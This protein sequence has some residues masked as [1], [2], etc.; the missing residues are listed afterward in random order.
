MREGSDMNRNVLEPP[1]EVRE[2]MS[3]VRTRMQLDSELMEWIRHGFSLIAAGFGSF[4]F[5]EGLTGA[6]GEGAD[7][8]ATEPSRVLSLVATA[9]GVILIAIALKHNRNMVDFVNADEFGAGEVPRVPNEKREVYL[10]GVAILMGIVSFL[11]LLF[12]Q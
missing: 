10:A 8:I 7:Q 1:S 9:I 11:A 12:L 4:A 2:Q 3:W 5:L 6:L